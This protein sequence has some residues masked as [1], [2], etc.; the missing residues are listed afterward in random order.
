MEFHEVEKQIH[1]LKIGDKKV[2]Y[3]CSDSS[4]I[5]VF[6]PA[7]KTT[8][9]KNIYDENLNFQIYLQPPGGY[10]FKPTHMRVLKSLY[11][12]IENSQDCRD[13]V[14]LAL[15]NIFHGTCP[16]QCFE[17]I[18]PVFFH[19]QLEPIDT[20]L[21]LSQL[22]MVEQEFNWGKYSPKHSHFDPP[23][24]FFMGYIRM[25]LVG[26]WKLGVILERVKQRKPPLEKFTSQD[27]KKHED[28]NEKKE[29]L[30]YL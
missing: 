13:R 25:V 24:L 4:E 3:K 22:L 7:E 20:D 29:T 18:S 6:R 5:Y 26:E 23:Y 1:K 2:L 14:L 12:N 19:E 21:Y 17:G 27:N 10:V 15:E 28:Y 11:L 9:L 16:N 8:W 30:W